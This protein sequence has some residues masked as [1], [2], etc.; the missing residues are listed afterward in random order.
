MFRPRGYYVGSS[1]VG[2]LPGNVKMVFATER[3]Y[4]EYISDIE[5]HAER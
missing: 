5:D 1:Y 3:E 4:M 2:F